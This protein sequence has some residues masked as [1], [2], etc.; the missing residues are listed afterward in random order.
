MNNAIDVMMNMLRTG[1]Q[2]SAVLTR[3]LQSSD[4]R[5]MQIQNMVQGKTQNEL[6]QIV[7]NMCKERGTTPEEVAR[8]LGLAAR[9]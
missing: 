1:M 7:C 5:I 9:R 6:Y 3:L 2:P 8:S 4:P